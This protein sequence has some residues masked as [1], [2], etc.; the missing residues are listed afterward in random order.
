MPKEGKRKKL[1]SEEEEGMPQRRHPLAPDRSAP[2]Y[3]HL[4]DLIYD[5]CAQRFRKKL[6]TNPPEIEGLTEIYRLLGLI[7]CFVVASFLLVLH[8]TT[9][10]PLQSPPLVLVFPGTHTQ[11]GR[12]RGDPKKTAL[13]KIMSLVTTAST[14]LTPPSGTLA[15]PPSTT[16]P[17]R[18]PAKLTPR[19][20]IPALRSTP[21]MY[22]ASAVRCVY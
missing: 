2:I 1:E 16:N 5:C 7:V 9:S 17:L 18:P 14:H 19:L 10:Q 4:I 22:P 3:K 20:P 8:R 11:G 6:P 15:A 13:Q 12:S 21:G